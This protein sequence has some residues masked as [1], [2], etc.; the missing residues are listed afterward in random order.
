MR[1]GQEQQG[2]WITRKVSVAACAW[3][4]MI[5]TLDAQTFTTPASFLLRS[6]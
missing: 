5:V 6:D 4:A 3:A 1:V 2:K